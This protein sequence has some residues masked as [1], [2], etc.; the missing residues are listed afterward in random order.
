MEQYLYEFERNGHSVYVKGGG[1]FGP[2]VREFLLKIEYNRKNSQWDMKLRGVMHIHG[3]LILRDEERGKE[4]EW[5]VR[6]WR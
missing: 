6:K 3:R 2:V 5:R 1:K 4:Q